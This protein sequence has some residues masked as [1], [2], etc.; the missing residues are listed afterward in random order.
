MRLIG[1]VKR[2]EGS[3]AAREAAPVSVG[4]AWTTRDARVELEELAEGAFI[5]VDVTLQRG[6]GDGSAPYWCVIER[7]TFDAADLGW[8]YELGASCGKDCANCDRVRAGRVVSID[9]DMVRYELF[10]GPR[11]E[12][13]F[14][15]LPAEW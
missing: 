1:A 11:C 5:A 9:T 8:F 2:L 6:G 14:M 7:P 10:E 4:I 13:E 12:R 15:R 3:A